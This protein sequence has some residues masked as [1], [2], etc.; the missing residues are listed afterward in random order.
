MFPPVVKNMTRASAAL[1]STP[2]D[3]RR[4][5]LNPVVLIRVSCST[6]SATTTSLAI[7][8]DG[9]SRPG[10]NW[11]L[12]VHSSLLNSVP[13]AVVSSPE[14]KQI[15][16]EFP[17]STTTGTEGERTRILEQVPGEKT[18]EPGPFASAS[19]LPVSKAIGSPPAPEATS[20]DMATPGALNALS[21][22]LSAL[23]S[24]TVSYQTYYTESPTA[25]SGLATATTTVTVSEFPTS[26]VNSIISSALGSAPLSPLPASPSVSVAVNTAITS[27]TLTATQTPLVPESTSPLVISP[28]SSNLLPTTVL[29]PP[30]TSAPRTTTAAAPPSTT[31]P[32]LPP[33]TSELTTPPTLLPS[34]PT[35]P[36]TSALPTT[37][38]VI[39]T[40]TTPPL[41]PSS[42]T[43]SPTSSSPPPTTPIISSTSSTFS[44]TT[45]ASSSISSSSFLTSPTSSTMTTFSSSTTS[46]SSES[47]SEAATST[48]SKSPSETRA[49]PVPVAGAAGLAFPSLLL[50]CGV[51]VAAAVAVR[52]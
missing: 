7:Q 8:K 22:L 27:P 23:S 34:S 39:P 47:S 1:Y 10:Q 18:Q 51:A 31:A 42:T 2:D 5:I 29:P 4:I 19:R 11:W 9:E 41:T 37:P 14:N 40:T 17:L 21:V 26:V 43:P 32:I 12:T 15:F 25:V 24:V 38:P 16:P 28:P 50:W 36:N 20:V 46:S 6:C 48:T 30:A 52:V 3:R 33:T 35:L 13:T 44:T 49:P 45:S